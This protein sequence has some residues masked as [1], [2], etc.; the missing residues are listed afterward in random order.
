MVPAQRGG[1]SWQGGLVGVVLHDNKDN[2][3]V[4][5]QGRPD[6]VALGLKSVAAQHQCGVLCSHPPPITPGGTTLPSSRNRVLPLSDVPWGTDIHIISSSS[7]KKFLHPF[8]GDVI[9]V[10]TLC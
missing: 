8:M 9:S 1:E 7:M 3:D 5:P 6:F 2:A 10:Q 4:I